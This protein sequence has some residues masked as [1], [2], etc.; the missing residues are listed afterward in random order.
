[1]KNNKSWSKNKEKK[2]PKFQARAPQNEER[3]IPEKAPVNN[4]H[5]EDESTDEER[6]KNRQRV[7]VI[8]SR[9]D[10]SSDYEIP[11]IAPDLSDK[12]GRRTEQPLLP[13]TNSEDLRALL[14][15]KAATV[16]A[17]KTDLRTTIN[18]SKA[19]KVGQTVV[20]PSLRPQITDLREQIN[21]K[22][23]IHTQRLD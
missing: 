14:K 13:A 16:S 12:L 22:S 15:R 7:E 20:A 6:P 21:P 18:K 1:M 10:N 3:F 19:I 5:L 17:S 9:P 11:P 4:L 8:L 23:L 2:T